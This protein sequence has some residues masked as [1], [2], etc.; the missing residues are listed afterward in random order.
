ML[1]TMNFFWPV[2][3]FIGSGSLEYKKLFKRLLEIR[4]MMSGVSP[5]NE[6]RSECF[7]SRLI[8]YNFVRRLM[9][10]CANF[11]LEDNWKGTVIG[12]FELS[13]VRLR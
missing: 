9:T 11:E 4:K 3:V 1:P 6:G 10:Q 5:R 12:C 7:S 8:R 13:A 2:N